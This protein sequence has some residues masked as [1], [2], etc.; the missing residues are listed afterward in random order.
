MSEVLGKSPRW[1][2]YGEEGDLRFP[3]D[4]EMKLLDAFRHMPDDAKTAL[5]TTANALK[6][7]P[8]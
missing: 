6:S 8:E 7:K 3:T 5:L 2:L 4:E 1:I